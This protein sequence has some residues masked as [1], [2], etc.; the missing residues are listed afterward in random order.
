VLKGKGLLTGVGD[1]GGFAPNLGSNQE[2]LELLIQAIEQAGY[3]PGKQVALALDVAASEFY[4]DGQYT[5]DGTAHSPAELI[6]YLADFSWQVP[7]C[8][9]RRWSP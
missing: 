8:L 9:H 5:Y 7:D 2:A 6:D 4:K 3:E 1:E